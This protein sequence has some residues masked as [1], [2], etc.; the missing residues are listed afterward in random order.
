MGRRAEKRRFPLFSWISEACDAGVV[1]AR[2]TKVAV[3]TRAD[4]T[5][6]RKALCMTPPD[7]QE[8]RRARTARSARGRDSPRFG[9]FREAKNVSVRVLLDCNAVVHLVDSQDLRVPAVATKFVI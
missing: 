8:S 5:M 6:A 7:L 9:V 2:I 4:A 3:A 1:S